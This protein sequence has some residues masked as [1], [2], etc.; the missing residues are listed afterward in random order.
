MNR[1]IIALISAA[2]ALSLFGCHDYDTCQ[3]DAD[4]HESRYCRDNLCALRAEYTRCVAVDGCPDGMECDLSLAICVPSDVVELDTGSDP[5]VDPDADPDL[6]A[7]GASD[8]ESDV[9][10]DGATAD[11]DVESEPDAVADIDV[12]ADADAVTDVDDTSESDIVAEPDAC[13]TAEVELCDGVD[14]TCE[15]DIDEGCDADGDGWCRLDVDEVVGTRPL[16]PEGYGDCDD[17][18]DT[19]S[20]TYPGAPEVCDA[21]PNDCQSETESLACSDTAS[22][23]ASSLADDFTA[24]VAGQS[25]EA[26]IC[27]MWTAGEFVYLSDGASWTRRFIGAGS[28]L[29]QHLVWDGEQFVGIWTGD[30]SA[31]YLLADAECVFTRDPGELE[32]E[33]RSGVRWV[34]STGTQVHVAAIWVFIGPAPAILPGVFSE[35][36]SLAYRGAIAI[37]EARSYDLAVNLR[38][39]TVAISNVDGTARLFDYEHGVEG[40]S[41]TPLAPTFDLI[42]L[43]T[44]PAEELLVVGVGPISTR[45]DLFALRLDADREVSWGPVYAGLDI[46]TD[47]FTLP[48]TAVE[49]NGAVFV[50]TIEES[51]ATRTPVMAVLDPVMGTWVDS[52]ADTCR[53]NGGTSEDNPFGYFNDPVALVGHQALLH[54]PHR[55]TGGVIENRPLNCVVP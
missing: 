33:G 27:F 5:Q 22:R 46:G 11:P 31:W 34:G 44:L 26:D 18:A 30:G 47:D 48:V 25:P 4:C 12:T 10:G 24:P 43:V 13:E 8:G 20:I 15:G 54:Y 39:G 52:I 6:V 35:E 53:P 38:L 32:D 40:Y 19:G 7:D 55:A 1:P 14:N 50:A 42:R 9:E 16:C 45:V 29:N 49:R 37:D 28:W 2:L 17:D 21:Q 36:G 3:N 23:L 51:G 41:V